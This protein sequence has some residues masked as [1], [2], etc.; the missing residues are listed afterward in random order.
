M[1]LKRAFVPSSCHVGGRAVAVAGLVSAS[2]WPSGTARAQGPPLQVALY[3]SG[4]GQVATYTVAF[5]AAAPPEAGR[6]WLAVVS[7][8]AVVSPGEA[9]LHV[10][11]DEWVALRVRSTGHDAELSLA[12]GWEVERFSPEVQVVFRATNPAA[13]G[14]YPLTIRLLGVPL[15][16]PLTRTFLVVPA[17]AVDDPPASLPLSLLPGCAFAEQQ[18][19]NDSPQ[20]ARE[21]LAAVDEA[22]ASEGL[23]PMYLPR[24]YPHLTIPE[25][26]LVVVDLE[27]EARGLPIFVGLS[28]SL[29]SY[30][31][32]GAEAGGDPV[33]PTGAVWGSNWAGGAPSALVSDWVWVYDDG[34]GGANV[35]CTPRATL[36]CWGH[37]RNVLG[38][39]GLSPAMGAGAY[40]GGG[41]A[42]ISALFVGVPPPPLGGWQWRVPPGSLDVSAADSW[43][44]R[45]P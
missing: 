18:R 2:L 32:A 33:G 1:G 29:D 31:Q 9:F 44:S 6:P 41:G 8:A 25:Q 7:P 21:A 39:Y 17:Q 16:K 37:R 36:G 4:A 20:C 11:R 43:P 14:D 42:S 24:Y 38:D 27:R 12:P 28:K 15:A 40:V 10:E 13:P 5:A 35:D 34:P 30:A 45:A 19:V 22:R 23:G 26:L 3:P